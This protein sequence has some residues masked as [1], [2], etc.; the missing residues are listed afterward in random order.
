MMSSSEH[1]LYFQGA[2]IEPKCFD[3]SRLLLFIVDSLEIEVQAAEREALDN[4]E[5]TP[6]LQTAL[7]EA[8][9]LRDDH[10]DSLDELMED[11]LTYCHDIY[12]Y[13]QEELNKAG[14]VSFH[15]LT[16]IT[17]EFYFNRVPGSVSLSTADLLSFHIP[18][19]WETTNENCPSSLD[20]AISWL[21]RAGQSVFQTEIDWEPRLGE[22]YGSC[23]G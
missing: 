10:Y 9:M 16:D 12:E 3:S 7:C 18:M 23:Y 1:G 22:L 6:E 2:L 20:E 11:V 21:Q 4:G 13:I 14:G 8:F 5:L 17:G 15:H 19:A